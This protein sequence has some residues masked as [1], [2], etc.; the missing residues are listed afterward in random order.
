MDSR[1]QRRPR[2]KALKQRSNPPEPLNTTLQTDQ[3]VPAKEQSPTSPSA[4]A[5]EDL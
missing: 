5:H 4:D 1:S 3:G 2:L